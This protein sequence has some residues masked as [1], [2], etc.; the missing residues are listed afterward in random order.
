MNIP[1]MPRA[2]KTALVTGASRG[3]GLEW[4]KQLA[5][6]Q[7]TVYAACRAGAD[8]PSLQ[9]LAVTPVMLDIADPASVAKLGDIL[10]GVSLDLLVNN[11]GIRPEEC[12]PDKKLG[13]IDFGTMEQ[14]MTTNSVGPIRVLSACLPALARAGAF[15][16]INI[17]SALG[18]C[19]L[20]AHTRK[21]FSNIAGTDLAYRSSK[22]ALNMATALAALE[23]SE[24]HP[25]SVVVTMDPGWVATDMGLRGG[26][27]SPP[28]NAVD[29]VRKNIERMEGLTPADTGT[30]IS[31][32]RSS[33]AV[34]EGGSIGYGA[35]ELPW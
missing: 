32:P 12:G 11:A 25:Q 1:C 24:V 5:D 6:K 13:E 7:W 17:S 9:G 29:A 4:A 16:V 26:K 35:S 20:A 27:D 23:L 10:E 33:P 3:L 22:A 28:L 31:G 34:Q 21:A 2:M 15:K 8:A 30:Y 18:S 19:A 14:V